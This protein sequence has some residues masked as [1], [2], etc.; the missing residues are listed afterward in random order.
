M[1]K[2]KFYKIIQGKIMI[3]H[4]NYNNKF[5]EEKKIIIKMIIKILLENLNLLIIMK[6]FLNNE[7]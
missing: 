4:L 3:R 1:M 6:I 7:K 5:N 2:I